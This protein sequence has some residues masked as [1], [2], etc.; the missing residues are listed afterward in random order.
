MSY[1]V[2]YYAFIGIILLLFFFF[3][4]YQQNNVF[5]SLPNQDF[6]EENEFLESLPIYVINMDHSKEKLSS[7]QEELKK[8][9]LYHNYQRWPAVDGHRTKPKE[10]LKYGVDPGFAQRKPGQS[11]CASSHRCI[12]KNMVDNNIEWAFIMEDDAFFHPDFRKLFPVYWNQVPKEAHIIFLGYC[13]PGGSSSSS[14]LL[15][16]GGVTGTHAYII[17]VE[18]AKR[19]L[20]H[21][22]PVDGP[23]DQMIKKFCDRNKDISY[24][25]RDTVKV[26]GIS[27]LR[28][29]QS[30][31]KYCCRGI[32]YQNRNDF[33]S[34]LEKEARED[35]GPFQIFANIFW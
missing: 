1:K 6:S 30:Q 10:F 24:I 9:N 8:V 35:F 3:Y 12:W 20:N 34:D 21:T 28:Y 15:K 14:T 26:N 11:G 31:H 17:N 4:S 22:K 27:P 18:V 16:R 25:F 2:P 7:I 23:I 29:S 5:N 32:V 33:R 13:W 19:L